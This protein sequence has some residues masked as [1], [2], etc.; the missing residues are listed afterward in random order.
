MS[1]DAHDL[2]KA[3]TRHIRE[4]SIA[5]LSLTVPWQS[6]SQYYL[7]GKF[8]CTAA[9]QTVRR[10]GLWIYRTWRGIQTE[11]NK[12]DRMHNIWT[13]NWSPP[14]AL[15]CSYCLYSRNRSI[16]T[17]SRSRLPGRSTVW[18]SSTPPFL[19]RSCLQVLEGYSF[20]FPAMRED[21]I[22]GYMVTHEL[23]QAKG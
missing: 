21:C 22:A 7:I 23:I 1:D 16:H 17:A 18:P 14:T 6:R 11:E 4:R 2:S 8:E 19:A 20:T 12:P 10:E 15:S 9:S 13:E 5:N 3:T